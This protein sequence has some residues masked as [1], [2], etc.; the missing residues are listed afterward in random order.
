MT[1]IPVHE[2]TD[3]HTSP[4]GLEILEHDLLLGGERLLRPSK[5]LAVVVVVLLEVGYV[6]RIVG[7]RDP[8]RLDLLLHQLGE[9]HLLE[10]GVVLDVAVSSR[11]ASCR[12]V[13]TPER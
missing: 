9:V 6:Q 12:G 2:P 5:V 10:E 3:A 13:P 4:R 1:F 7:V 11:E 8:R